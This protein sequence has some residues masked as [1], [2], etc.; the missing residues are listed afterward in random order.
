M[1]LNDDEKLVS[2]FMDNVLWGNVKIDWKRILPTET[3]KPQKEK[4]IFHMGSYS[5]MVKM[6]P[7]PKDYSTVVE[8]LHTF[9][10]VYRIQG[11]IEG[12]LRDREEEQKI[13]TLEDD[14]KKLAAIIADQ[15][16]E[17]SQLYKESPDKKNIRGIT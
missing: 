10:V 7:K 14:N 15:K 4:I 3:K 5:V 1:L 12:E 11:A 16:R 17:L 9:F 6:D 8:K 13:K 2:L